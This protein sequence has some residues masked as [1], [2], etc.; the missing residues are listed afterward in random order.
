MRTPSLH[1]AY[2]PRPPPPSTGWL[3][4]ND[5]LIRPNQYG[6]PLYAVASM[7]GISAPWGKQPRGVPPPIAGGRRVAS[8]HCPLPTAPAATT[9]CRAQVQGPALVSIMGNTG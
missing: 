1:D 7:E 4:R 6:L 3:C 9:S 2:C 5:I 8:S